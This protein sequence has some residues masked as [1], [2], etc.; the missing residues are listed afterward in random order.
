MRWRKTGAHRSPNARRERAENS[1]AA[2]GGM[3]NQTIRQWLGGVALLI[4]A[5]AVAG[6]EALPRDAYFGDLHVHTRYSF[7]AFIFNVRATPEDA[8]RYARGETIEHAFGFPMRLRGEPLDFMA[9]TDH[10]TYLGVLSA[11]GDAQHALSKTDIA[12]KLIS[13]DPTVYL[14]A[15]RGVAASII[16]GQ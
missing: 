16:T 3:N 8:Y 1:R 13:T 9:V 2:E 12:K 15:F 11:M 14:P 6:S 5:S 7:D 10:A 4:A